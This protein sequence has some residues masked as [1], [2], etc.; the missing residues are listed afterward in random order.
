M[1]PILKAALL[2]ASIA[3]AGGAPVLAEPSVT[4]REG[5][6]VRET[7]YEFD[8]LLDRLSDAVKAE[9]MLRLYVASASRGAKGRGIDIPGNAVMGVYRNDFAVRMLEAS[10]DAGV[11]A[12]IIFY[13]T[14]DADGG[15]T[16]SYKTPSLVFAPYMDQG[17]DKLRALAADLDAKFAAIAERAVAP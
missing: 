4:P 15:A 14:E 6:V 8:A 17:G 10:V 2:A 13:V 7:D 16:L 12:P 9:K 5:W 1:R 11:E 3:L